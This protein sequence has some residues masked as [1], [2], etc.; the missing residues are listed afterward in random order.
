LPERIP[1][2][3]KEG[4][5]VNYTRCACGIKIIWPRNVCGTCRRPTTPEQREAM[6][7]RPLNDEQLEILEADTL[8]I[9]AGSKHYTTETVQRLIITLR[10]ASPRVRKETQPSLFQ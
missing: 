5:E 2:P 10:L 4:N 6:A 7:M 3:V 1:A 8:R 9:N